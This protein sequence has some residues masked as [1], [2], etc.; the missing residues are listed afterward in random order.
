[1]AAMYPVTVSDATVRAVIRELRGDGAWPSG[2]A[3]R[4]E[5]ARRYGARGGTTRIY[6][7]LAEL[8]REESSSERAQQEIAT[9]RA[10]AELA[11]QREVAHQ[12]RWMREVD[13]L[14]QQLAAAEREARR[15]A[16]LEKTVL[17][18]RRRVVELERA[19]T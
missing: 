11:E 1:M 18:L 6:R 9:L 4:A 8:R 10:R 16:D 7:L 12:A 17:A 14:R 2:A 3:L 13:Q 15:V 19:R 5:L